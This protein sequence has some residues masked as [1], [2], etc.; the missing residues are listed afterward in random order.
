MNESIMRVVRR[1]VMAGLGLVVLSGVLGCQGRGG[2]EERHP[3][4]PGVVN[5]DVLLDVQAFRRGTTL[6]MTNT[7]TVSFERARVWA[8]RTYSREISGF[9]IGET[10]RV[11]LAAFRNEYGQRFEAGGFFATARPDAL[12]SVEIEADGVM[13]RVV[14]VEDTIN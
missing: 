8:N 11:G 13:Y 14:V 7:S 3:V 6:E 9:R 10:I 5:G 2:I 12:V 4:Y 1:G